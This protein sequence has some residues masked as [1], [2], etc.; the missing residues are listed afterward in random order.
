[1]TATEKWA[2]PWFRKL[3]PKMKL[4]WMFLLDECTH[5]GIWEPDLEAVNFHIGV[6]A[7]TVTTGDVEKHLEG[8]YTVLPDGKWFI[9]KFI[10]FQYKVLE[11]GNPAHRGVIATL[12]KYGL[13]DEDLSVKGATKPLP[14]PSEGAKDKDKAKAKDKD[15][16]KEKGNG[17][18]SLQDVVDFVVS[19]GLPASDG[20][21]CHAKWDG[22]GFTNGGK[23]I[24]R[25]KSVI[26]SHKIAGY[27]P[28]QK[29]NN[30][31]GKLQGVTGTSQAAR[32]T[33]RHG[34]AE[35]KELADL[36]ATLDKRDRE[37]GQCS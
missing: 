2:D 18:P 14:S 10:L 28:S 29:V 24:A 23:K 4:F 9:P 15:K 8:R 35:I 6:G 13:L 26:Q 12:Q 32:A 36:K 19:L 20:E 27:L 21:Y 37:R 16:D 1:M 31:S 30:G 7:G 3:P 11:T 22:N 34:P 33:F 5:A 25:W 17:L